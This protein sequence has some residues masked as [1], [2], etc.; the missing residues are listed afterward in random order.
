MN[1][2]YTRRAIIGSDIKKINFDLFLGVTNE[3][4]NEILNYISE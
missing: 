1:R 4:R 2:I 3:L